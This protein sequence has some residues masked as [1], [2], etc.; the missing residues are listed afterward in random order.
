MLPFRM[1]TRTRRNPLASRKEQ[2]EYLR[3]LPV[4]MAGR[5]VDLVASQYGLYLAQH[6]VFGSRKKTPND[7]LMASLETHKAQYEAAGWTPDEH[8][9]LVTFGLAQ[10]AHLDEYEREYVI[11]EFLRYTGE[12]LG[13]ERLGEA[14]IRLKL[15]EL[16][17]M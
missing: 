17:G 11:A 2:L 5:Q 10:T 4:A 13:D 9:A 16:Q 12:L 15:Y 14:E 7:S 3:K 8:L 1:N 6:F